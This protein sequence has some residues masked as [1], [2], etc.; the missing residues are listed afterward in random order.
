MSFLPRSAKLVGVEYVN[1]IGPE[2]AWNCW[3]NANE[4]SFARNDRPPSLDNVERGLV[5]PPSS[6]MSATMVSCTVAKA[7][8][9]CHFS[10]QWKEATHTNV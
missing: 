10:T 4:S 7:K 2:L 1:N 5:A 8:E 9:V 3:W 6:L